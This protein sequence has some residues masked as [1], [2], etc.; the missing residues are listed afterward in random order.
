MLMYVN[1]PLL[2]EMIF[3]NGL[4]L[5]RV[6]SKMCNRKYILIVIS[7]YK[8]YPKHVVLFAY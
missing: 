2:C 3:I 6:Q 1:D 5:A 4:F 8:I 7:I